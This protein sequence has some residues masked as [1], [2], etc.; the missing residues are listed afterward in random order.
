MA[1]FL[2]WSFNIGW[3]TN[4]SIIFQQRAPFILNYGHDKEKYFPTSA[5]RKSSGKFQANHLENV[6]IASFYQEIVIISQRKSILHALYA[7]FK[8]LRYIVIRL[9]LKGLLGTR[10]TQTV[11]LKKLWAITKVLKQKH[12]QANALEHEW[13]W[14]EWTVFTVLF[15][16]SNPSDTIS[17]Q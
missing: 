1:N 13:T 8:G 15:D 6:L 10:R 7:E 2:T 4:A 17:Y 16:R 3:R 14:Q 11:K 12:W 9:L 5:G